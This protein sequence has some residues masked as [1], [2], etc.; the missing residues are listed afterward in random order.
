MRSR[1]STTAALVV[2]V[3][4]A[5]A[6]ALTSV[7]SA[8]VTRL[9][10]TLTGAAEVPK[11]DGGSASAQINLNPATGRVCWAFT[12]IKGIRSPQAAHIHK[13]PKGK[14]GAVVVPL[15]G[16]FKAKGCTTASAVL[17]AAIAAHPSAYYVNIHTKK[18]PGGA[19]RGQLGEADGS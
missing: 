3:F 6:L 4:V 7:A 5:A 8:K 18:Y 19:L 12:K 16:A 14:A 17:T 13:A 15:G 10:A 1:K 11:A 9:S 2:L